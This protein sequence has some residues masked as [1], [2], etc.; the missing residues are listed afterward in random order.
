MLLPN[1]PD[2]KLLIVSGP[3]ASGKSALAIELAQQHNG[4]IINGDALQVYAEMRI[5]TARPSQHDE[6]I[7]PHH[8]YGYHS[9]HDHHSVTEWIGDIKPVIETAWQ[10]DQLPIVVGGTGF[11]LHTLLHG[12]SSV[13]DV[14]DSV[15]HDTMELYD[16]IGH[17]AFRAE[18]RGIDPVLAET[19]KPNDKQRLVRAFE[20]YQATHQPLSHWQQQPRHPLFPQMR[21]FSL[22]LQPPRAQLYAR[23]NQR[24]LDMIDQGALA[25]ARDVDELNPDP[26]LP[27]CKALGLAPLRDYIHERIT[28]EQAVD[29]GQTTSRQYAKRQMTWLRTQW[30]ES[31]QHRIRHLDHV[32]SATA[33][34]QDIHTQLILL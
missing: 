2:H 24:F 12:M 15:R 8:L 26:S 25:E 16:R 31:E 21:S 29:L 5:L 23:I 14:P 18:L 11:Y 6:T 30:M 28:L 7:V 9:I 10:N 34:Q 17:D 13:P 3:T 20:V 33:L 27:G 22:L 32:P 19:I 1:N 4:I